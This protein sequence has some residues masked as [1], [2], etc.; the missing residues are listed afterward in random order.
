MEL[1]NRY[2]KSKADNYI[3]W[4]SLKSSSSSSKL[5]EF[6]SKLSSTRKSPKAVSIP[7]W[8]VFRNQIRNNVSPPK[9]ERPK[10]DH[11]S[12][13]ASFR[14]NSPKLNGSPLWRSRIRNVSIHSNVS[15]HSSPKPTKSNKITQIIKIDDLRK[16]IEVLSE[17]EETEILNLPDHYVQEL[18]EFCKIVREKIS[19]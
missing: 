3:K 1:S 4:S 5:S 9:F 11:Y 18:R 17:A 19:H 10:L 14:S 2:W 15:G 6:Y 12:N 13:L 8:K 7:S 16:A